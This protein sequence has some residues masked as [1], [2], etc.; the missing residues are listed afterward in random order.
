VLQQ[1]SGFSNGTP[2]TSLANFG[3]T[4]SDTGQLSVDTSAFT[5]AA[6]SDFSTLQATL[7]GETTGGFL[8][9]ATS[10]LTGIEDPTQGSLKVEENT[11]SSEITAQNTTISN[12]QAKITQLQTNITAQM[13]QADAAIS[14]LESQL[15]YVNGLFY[16]ITGNNN[17]PTASGIA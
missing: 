9:A 17:N 4:V 13:V 10:A 14:A 15:S 3:I 11:V 8:E 7:G 6:N 2:D 1:L 16:S 12:E 5:T